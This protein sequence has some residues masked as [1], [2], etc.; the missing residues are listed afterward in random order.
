MDP[1][2]SLEMILR[3]V[4]GG[5]WSDESEYAADGLSDWIGRKGGFLPNRLRSLV[6]DLREEAD[7]FFG[8]APQSFDDGDEDE[9]LV[10]RVYIRPEGTID[11]ATGDP[12]FD[13][14]HRGFCG[15]GTVSRHDRKQDVIASLCDAF[16]EA[17]DH[18]CATV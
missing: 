14:D 9:S 13:A 17:V 4:A 1:N 2:A 7:A 6:A 3:D 16:Y 18:Y 15:C 5:V 10:F 11:I 8:S 12:S